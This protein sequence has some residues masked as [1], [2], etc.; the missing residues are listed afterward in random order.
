M[1]YLSRQISSKQ[2][3]YFC[4]TLQDIITLMI[5]NIVCTHIMIRTAIYSKVQYISFK[6]ISFGESPSKVCLPKSILE[7]GKLIAQLMF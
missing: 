3:D 4:K 1:S 5:V 2:L 7:R 6:C